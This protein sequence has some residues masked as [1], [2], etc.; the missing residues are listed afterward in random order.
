VLLNMPPGANVEPLAV[1]L[2]DWAR[3]VWEHVSP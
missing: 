3:R 2:E 1:Q